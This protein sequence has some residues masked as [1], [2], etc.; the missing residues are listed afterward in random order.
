MAKIEAAT[1]VLA[2]PLE[3]KFSLDGY[4]VDCHRI[5]FVLDADGNYFCGKQNLENPAF[6]NIK[7]ELI[8]L[9]EIDLKQKVDVIDEEPIKDVP[10]DETPIDVKP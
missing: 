2:V 5:E 7:S 1:K 3:K 8:A 9:T 4:Q 6:K 10:I